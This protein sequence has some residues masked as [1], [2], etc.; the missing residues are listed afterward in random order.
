[1]T[2][3]VE[4]L[5]ADGFVEKSRSAGDGRGMDV[6]LTQRGLDRLVEAYPTHLASVR[7]RIMDHIDRASSREFGQAIAAVVQSF[8]DET[9]PRGRRS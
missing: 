2:R 7:R 6:T 8:E 9:E 5:A 1:M 3:L 4:E